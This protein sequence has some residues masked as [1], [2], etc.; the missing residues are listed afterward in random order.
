MTKPLHYLTATIDG[1]SMYY[2]DSDKHNTDSQPIVFIHGFLTDSSMWQAQIDALKSQHRCIAIDLWSHGQSDPMPKGTT[3][4][5]TIAEQCLSLLSSLGLNQFRLVANG[6]GCAIAAEMALISPTSVTKMVMANGFIGFEPQVNCIKYQQWIDQISQQQSCSK[7]MADL[8]TEQYFANLA[9]ESHNNEVSHSDN[10]SDAN[11]NNS[12]TP[13]RFSQALQNL[14]P[15]NIAELVLMAPLFLYKRDTLELAE[16]LTLPCLILVG[17]QNKL[18]TVLEA[19][20][21]QDCITGSTLKQLTA[22]GHLAN[23]EQAAMVNQHLINFF[24]S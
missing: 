15:N 9:I 21:M 11:T 5:V 12:L 13:E 2:S 7:E 18:R 19:Y 24:E 20:L 6:S 22:A 14:S 8:I 16:Q 3:S 17:E 4:L 1:Q 10:S 23:V